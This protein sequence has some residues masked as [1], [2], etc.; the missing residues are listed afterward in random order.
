MIG[1]LRWKDHSDGPPL[2]TGVQQSG[3]LAEVRVKPVIVEDRSER[4]ALLALKIEEGAVSQGAWAPLRTGR[5]SQADSLLESPEN[6]DFS[7]VRHI[8]P[9]NLNK[10]RNLCY[11]KPLIFW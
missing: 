2:I 3:E 5:R 8:A 11:F 10:I 7:P 9:V 6:A 4:C 1:T